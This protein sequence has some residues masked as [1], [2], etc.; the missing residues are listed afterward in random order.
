MSDIDLNG[1]SFV[2]GGKTYQIPFDPPLSSYR[3]TRERVVEMDKE[4]LQALNKSDIT[5]K[6]FVPPMISAFY[7]IEFLVIASTFLGYSQ[8]WWF[9]RG[10]IV[11]RL[12]GQGFAKFSWTI[13]PW[14]I[15]FMLGLH[16]AEAIYFARNQL[17]KHS[18][19]VRTPMFWKWI[20]TV[21]VEGQFAFKRFYDHVEGKRQEKEKQKQ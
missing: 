14:L 21:F 7:A 15:T 2:A 18:V 16:A 20:A 13:Q 9:A 8:R 11:E 19:N 12:L 17:W 6:E 5:V 1:M 4:C 10:A 3:E